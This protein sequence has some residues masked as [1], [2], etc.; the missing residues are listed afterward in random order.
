[1]SEVKSFTPAGSRPHHRLLELAGEFHVTLRCILE[2]G[3]DRRIA[4]SPCAL[5]L[6]IG[7]HSARLQGGGEFTVRQFECRQ[8]GVVDAGL[9]RVHEAWKGA[10]CCMACV[11]GFASFE[12]AEGPPVRCVPGKGRQQ[13]LKL[14]RR[15]TFSRLRPL[16][17]RGHRWIEQL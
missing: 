9:L 4:H 10:R 3:S 17:D 1:M 7:R 12:C 5:A 2:A 8:R 13:P 6:L 14:L 11:S 16:A 15:P